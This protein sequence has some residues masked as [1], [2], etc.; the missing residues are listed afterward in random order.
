MKKLYLLSITLL[1]TFIAMAEDV[2][3]TKGG[4]IY[5]GKIVENVEGN[6]L[7]IRLNDG[8]IFSCSYDDIDKITDEEKQKNTYVRKASNTETGMKLY[9]GLPSKGYRGFI[10]IAHSIPIGDW[11]LARGGFTTSH[12]YQICPYFFAGAGIGLHIYDRYNPNNQWKNHIHTMGQG[13]PL[14]L[15]IFAHLRSEF[16]KSWIS[17]YVDAKIGYSVADKSGLYFVSTIGVRI[18]TKVNGKEL[19]FSI[20][21]GFDFQRIHNVYELK[22]PDYWPLAFDSVDTNAIQ[23]VFGVDL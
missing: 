15:P 2:V 13:D 16:V 23:I 4:N 11:G 9:K 3:Y 14:S 22:Y 19:G 21:A 10:D 18:S 1:M 17:P 6:Y 7:R 12:G 5:R 8:G 20:G